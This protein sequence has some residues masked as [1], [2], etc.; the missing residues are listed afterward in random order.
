MNNIHGL[1]GV[2]VFHFKSFFKQMAFPLT[3]SLDLLPLQLLPYCQ[4][5]HVSIFF[6]YFR[7]Q[8]PDISLHKF[9]LS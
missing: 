4:K 1:E 3:P 7:P 2:V 5:N 9:T 6:L 8:T